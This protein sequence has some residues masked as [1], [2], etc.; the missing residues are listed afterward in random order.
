MASVLNLQNATL[1]GP[2]E[3][4]QELLK[5]RKGANVIQAQ[6]ATIILAEK[7]LSPDEVR[8]TLARLA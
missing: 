8:E 7:P 1:I 4:I 6:G 5:P 3:Y 2:L